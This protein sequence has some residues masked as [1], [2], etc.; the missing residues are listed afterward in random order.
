MMKAK[1]GEHLLKKMIKKLFRY[2]NKIWY[3]PLLGLLA[4]LDALFFFIPTDGLL[5]SSSM[6]TKKR[7]FLLG[8]SVAIGSTL[9]GLVVIYLIE[10]FGIDLFHQYYP[11][12]FKTTIWFKTEE[13][14]NLYGIVVLFF[15]GLLP[16]TQQPALILAGLSNTPLLPI[17]FSLLISRILKFLF[18]AYIASHSPKYIKKIW[19]F[20]KSEG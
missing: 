13:F 7:W 3:A 15:I 6:L 11:E 10:V 4:L 2:A 17:F 8:L 9:G 16:I 14:F 12:M 19:G 1:Q 18:M 5:V 20:P